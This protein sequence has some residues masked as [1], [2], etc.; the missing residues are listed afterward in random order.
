MANQGHHGFNV[1][2]AVSTALSSGARAPCALRGPIPRRHGL[3]TSLVPANPAKRTA[4]PSPPSPPGRLRPG[5]TRRVGAC[6]PRQPGP[7]GQGPT[8]TPSPVRQ[9]SHWPCRN[10]CFSLHSH[11]ER[12]GSSRPGNKQPWPRSHSST[13]DA[14][15]VSGQ[16]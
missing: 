15:Y 12:S 9:F 13:D 5:R 11:S 16:L 6:N 14:N 3:A 1:P 7:M 4:A 2:Q 8:S 10:L